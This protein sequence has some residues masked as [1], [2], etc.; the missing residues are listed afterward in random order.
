MPS[1][2]R[3]RRWGQVSLAKCYSPRRHLSDYLKLLKVAREL[4]RVTEGVLVLLGRHTRSGRHTESTLRSNADAP[5]R[6]VSSRFD[7]GG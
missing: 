3:P 7:P 2:D 5:A 1:V 4:R 6:H